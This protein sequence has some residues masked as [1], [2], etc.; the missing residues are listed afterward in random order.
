MKKHDSMGQRVFLGVTRSMTQA[1]VIGHP[2]FS[3]LSCRYVPRHITIHHAENEGEGHHRQQGGICFLALRWLVC[4]T[5]KIRI[6]DLMVLGWKWPP[7]TSENKEMSVTLD[8][9]VIYSVCFYIGNS[10]DRFLGRHPKIPCRKHPKRAFETWY[11]RASCTNAFF[12]NC[13]GTKRPISD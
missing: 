11:G 5:T 4:E 1:M 2:N 9:R 7:K 8:D 10:A 3:A 13:G 6:R 12:D